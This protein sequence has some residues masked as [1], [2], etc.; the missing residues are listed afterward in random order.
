MLRSFVA[1]RDAFVAMRTQQSSG[2]TSNLLE[3]DREA[4]NRSKSNCDCRTLLCMYAEDSIGLGKY[5]GVGRA[6][7][8]EVCGSPRMAH[9]E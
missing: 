6:V 7:T 3:I 4:E 2:N 8:P 9:R 5:K 1:P